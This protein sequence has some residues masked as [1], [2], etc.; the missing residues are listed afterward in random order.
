MSVS[1][2]FFSPPQREVSFDLA[3]VL[4]AARYFAEARQRR[5]IEKF[6]LDVENAFMKAVHDE[7]ANF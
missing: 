1:P 6:Q 2:S 5:D 4:E 3:D 7:I